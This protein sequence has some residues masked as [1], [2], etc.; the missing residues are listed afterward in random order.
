MYIAG[1]KKNND[2]LQSSRLHS[3]RL[4]F[5]VVCLSVLAA[6]GTMKNSPDEAAAGD[7]GAQIDAATEERNNVKDPFEGLN[8]VMYTFNDKMDRYL[9]KPVAK[10]YRAIT[11]KPVSKGIS[12]FFSN[13][14]DPAIMLYNFLQ[15]KPKAGASDLGR[16]LV[17]S[18]IGIAGLFDVATKM[19]LEKHNEDFGQTLAVWGV[20]DGPY[21]VLPFFGP[22]NIREGASI[23]VDWYT[24]PPNHMEEQSTNVKMFAVE[25]VD[26]RAQLLDAG[27]ILDQAAGADPYI[28][29][30]EAFRQRRLSLIYDGNP[31]QAAPPPGLFE[32]DEPVPNTSAQPAPGAPPQ[33]R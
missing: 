12:N 13:L 25:V 11:P 33:S 18:T 27:D 28:F 30:R 15:G 8:R 4:L 19:G 20:G 17:N 10:G 3:A 6:C 31:P 5:A 29:V 9:L 1:Q 7:S 23:P 21:L 16:F 32:D 26:R 14:H 22:S 24:Y 2:P